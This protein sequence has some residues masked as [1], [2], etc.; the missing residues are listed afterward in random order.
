MKEVKLAKSTFLVLSAQLLFNQLKIVCVHGGCRRRQELVNPLYMA[1]IS[2]EIHVIGLLKKHLLQL[3]KLLL[4]GNLN[5]FL[6]GRRRLV[7]IKIQI[8]DKECLWVFTT[9]KVEL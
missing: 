5:Q 1:Y 2:I 8:G 3:N 6:G 4:I 9:S 7:I